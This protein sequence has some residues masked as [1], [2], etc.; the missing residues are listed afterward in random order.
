MPLA[1]CCQAS[2]K[3]AT[4]LFVRTRNI[5]CW[6]TMHCMACPHMS[7]PRQHRDPP[8][9]S[10]CVKTRPYP[11]MCLFAGPGTCLGCMASCSRVLGSQAASH[12]SCVRLP[13]PQ[14]ADLLVQAVPPLSAADPA[15]AAGW[16]K[17]HAG[18]PRKG[19]SCRLKWVKCWWMYSACSPSCCLEPVFLSCCCAQRFSC[20]TVNPAACHR[21]VAARAGVPGHAGSRPV[22]QGAEVTAGQGC[23]THTRQCPGRSLYCHATPCLRAAAAQG[24]CSQACGRHVRPHSGLLLRLLEDL[25]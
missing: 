14:A 2:F 5:C 21:L 1:P 18:W 9:M 8:G 12:G 7:D 23:G 22:Q 13:P 3:D 6:P 16:R 24:H 10:T 11:L 17:A 19:A 15:D 25:R 4:Q 20:R